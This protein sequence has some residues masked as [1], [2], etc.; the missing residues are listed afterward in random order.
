VTPDSLEAVVG[1]VFAG[2]DKGEERALVVT[3]FGL[4][5]A[6]FAG[7]LGHH[8]VPHTARVV[9]FHDIMKLRHPGLLRHYF[10]NS[11]VIAV[12]LPSAGRRCPVF[13]AKMWMCLSRSPFSCKALAVHSLNLTRFH[14]DRR[15]ATFETA[16]LTRSA[17]VPLPD[18]VTVP[19]VFGSRTGR[20]RV[21]CDA[22]T[23]HINAEAEEV[24]V[25]TSRR[26]A[27][28][29]LEPALK[30]GRAVA[31]A[32][33]F[34]KAK[35]LTLLGGHDIP[36]YTGRRKGVDLHAKL[37][38]LPSLVVAGSIN[39]TAQAL[40][41]GSNRAVNTETVVTLRRPKS[42]SI[43]RMLHGFPRVR[44]DAIIGDGPPGDVDP[45]EDEP[46]WLEARQLAIAGPTKVWLV[47]VY[48]K[49]RIELLG[50]LH[51]TTR[52]QLR[53]STGVL[54][55][56]ATRQLFGR[57]QDQ[58]E[59]AQLLTGD[60]VE[61]AGFA[62]ERCVWRRELDLGDLW[63]WFE[64]NGRSAVKG[65]GAVHT[66]WGT[67]KKKRAKEWDDVRDLRRRAFA[68]RRLTAETRRWDDWWARYG[69]DRVR[70]MPA[71]C[72]QLGERL[73]GL[74]GRSG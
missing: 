12:R 10:P 21:S 26:P 41:I 27:C 5:E 33:P 49:A 55:A 8:G 9:V 59:L 64:H 61:V 6:V 40:G 16:M 7:L 4:D 19:R 58:K 34:V 52:V 74:R 47:L 53:S 1:A 48:G 51:G 39:L 63:S 14:L 15:S 31:C 66:T 25:A 30:T 71:W 62:S 69:A 46:N 38:E 50:T 67:G 23:V 28:A 60:E 42:F 35:A 37:I 73:R 45:S 18:L 54:E 13:H 24:Q 11:L 20:L 3:T 29:I 22:M 2:F 36:A 57:L 44:K 65:D 32:G 68:S 72:I 70:A 43:A 56:K 17:A